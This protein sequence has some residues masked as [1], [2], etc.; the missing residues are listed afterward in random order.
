MVPKQRASLGSE[1][2]ASPA[3]EGALASESD[4]NDAG[5]K[6]RAPAAALLLPVAISAVASLLL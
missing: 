2:E 5:T 1:S 6:A 3:E 4:I